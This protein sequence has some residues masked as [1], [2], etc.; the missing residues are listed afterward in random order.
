MGRSI[1]PFENS[2]PRESLKFDNTH[3]ARVCMY[4]LVMLFAISFGKF[5]SLAM[6]V[7]YIIEGIRG[8]V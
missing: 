7:V 4:V 8:R 1:S 6:G 2:L 5:F 3:I